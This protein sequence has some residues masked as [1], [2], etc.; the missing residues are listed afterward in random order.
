MPYL[1][2][3]WIP[4]RPLSS[5]ETL[6]PHHRRAQRAHNLRQKHLC[7]CAFWG[8]QKVCH[9][10]KC[11]VKAEFSQK[12]RKI[13]QFARIDASPLVKRE[14]QHET[15]ALH[16]SKQ[17]ESRKSTFKQEHGSSSGSKQAKTDVLLTT[18]LGPLRC[19]QVMLSK[20]AA[21]AAIRLFSRSARRWFEKHHTLSCLCQ[22]PPWRPGKACWINIV[23]LKRWCGSEEI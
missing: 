10:P 1:W 8:E 3:S 17:K 13:H 2:W 6:L 12:G 22:A 9:P 14:T 19:G 7:F 11:S 5:F 18:V 21:A 20:V 15:Y 4:T 23:A 16:P